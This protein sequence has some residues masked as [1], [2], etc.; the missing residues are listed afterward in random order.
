LESFGAGE[1]AER[2][3]GLLVLGYVVELVRGLELVLELEEKVNVGT[4]ARVGIGAGV[5]SQCWNGG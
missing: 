4:G 2:R 1:M 3:T 5:E